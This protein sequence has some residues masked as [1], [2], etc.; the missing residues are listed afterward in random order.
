MEVILNKPR[1]NNPN[2]INTTRDKKKNKIE[3]SKEKSR[4][5]SK[6]R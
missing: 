4:E 5:M 1:V 3:K 2:Y 6:S